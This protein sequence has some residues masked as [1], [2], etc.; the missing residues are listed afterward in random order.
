MG[1]GTRPMGETSTSGNLIEQFPLTFD[2]QR[3]NEGQVIWTQSELETE[4]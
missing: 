3:L 2:A 4:E 1:S